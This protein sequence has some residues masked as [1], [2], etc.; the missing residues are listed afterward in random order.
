MSAHFCN[1]VPI[2][3]NLS[4]QDSQWP[5]KMLWRSRNSLQRYSQN[6]TVFF[7]ILNFQCILHIF[8]NMSLQN[9]Q[10][11]K[12]TEW[13][14]NFFETRSQN[15]PIS[16]QLKHQSEFIFCVLRLSHKHITFDTLRWTPC[17]TL[18]K[19]FY[20]LNFFVRPMVKKRRQK[21]AKKHPKCAPPPPWPPETHFLG[22][23]GCVLS[24][25]CQKTP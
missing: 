18:L 9:L 25:Q 21:C 13:L 1:Y 19:L 10:R 6:N 5:H 11:W 8:T 24:D 17:M 16:V 2:F 23:G 14:W 22:W 12:I 20:F 15:G 3:F 4:S 7:L